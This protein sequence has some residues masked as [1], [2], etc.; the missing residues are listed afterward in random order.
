[1]ALNVFTSLHT[2]ILRKADC[3]KDEKDA[4]NGKMRR[5]L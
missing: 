3:M 2:W 5:R 1:M 4:K